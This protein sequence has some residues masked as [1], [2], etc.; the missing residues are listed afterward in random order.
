MA[1]AVGVMFGLCAVIFYSNALFVGQRWRLFFN[2]PP[3]APL[4]RV[5]SYVGAFAAASAAWALFS[6]DWTALAFAGIMLT[7]AVLGQKLKSFHLQV[8]YGI[9][10][11]LALYRVAVVN[12][13][14]DALENT[15]VPAR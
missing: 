6:G 14:S 4:L 2:D 8:Q 5:H 1:L 10:G 3:D 9:L 11:L 15:H 7:L 12:L 13:H